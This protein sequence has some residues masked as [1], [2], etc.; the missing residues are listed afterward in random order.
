MFKNF[1]FLI[2]RALIG[3]AL[4]QVLRLRFSLWRDRLPVDAL[5]LEGTMEVVILSEDEM[6][7]D[8]MNYSP[9]S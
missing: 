8:T 9:F 3:G 5:P 6:A 2:P 7:S 1:E 4:G